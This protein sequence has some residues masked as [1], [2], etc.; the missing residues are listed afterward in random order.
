MAKY[1]HIRSEGE[2][3]QPGFNFYPLSERKTH[4]GFYFMAGP[5]VFRMRWRKKG[6]T[7]RFVVQW[8]MFSPE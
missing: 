8:K 2:I 1:F 6:H 5:L 4:V 7:P 3:I